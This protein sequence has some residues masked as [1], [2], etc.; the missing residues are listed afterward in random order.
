MIYREIRGAYSVYV[1]RA[2]DC[3]LDMQELKQIIYQ[4]EKIDTEC[5]E[6]ESSVPKS[7]YETYSA[8][9]N[10]KGGLHYPWSERR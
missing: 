5:K 4:G 1:G 8:F 3:L 2:G 9:A 7:V 10:T 6:A